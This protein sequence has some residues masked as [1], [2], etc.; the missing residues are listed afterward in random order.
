MRILALSHDLPS[1]YFSDTL[2]VF[3]FLRNLSQVHGHQITLV[4][5]YSERGSKADLQMLAQFCTIGGIFPIK[6]TI[7]MH[8]KTLEFI[9]NTVIHN[10]LTR[11]E[12]GITAADFYFSSSM[13]HRVEDLL[14]EEND[15]V[16]LTWPMGDY[17]RHAS[18]PKVL[19]LFDALD[20]WNAQVSKSHRGVQKYVDLA[21]SLLFE[22]F[23]R[24]I[25]EFNVSLIPT[26]RDKT[27]VGR[28]SPSADIRV[29]PLGVDTESFKPGDFL[30]QRPSLIF[31]SDMSGAP[32]VTNVI[33]FYTKVYPIICRAIP[34][35]RLY[36]VG[37]NPAPE[38]ARLS[39]DPSVVVTGYV[40][41]VKPY[42]ARAHVFVAPMITGTGMKNKV[43][44]A[45]AMGKSIVSTAEGARGLDV[46]P[47]EH[48]LLAD[49]PMAFAQCVIALLKDEG[50]RRFL[51]ANARALVERKYSW[52][53][54]TGLMNMIIEET[55]GNRRTA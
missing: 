35:V 26:Q 8:Q 10:L 54:V 30:D 21:T 2:P 22:K 7:S 50:K 4:T 19:Q 27:L 16:Y 24:G 5:F 53:V 6:R 51:G 55:A 14:Q 38:I 43:L 13:A 15:L 23:E 36:L 41:S 44:E 47:G 37:R 31:V 46:V 9:S 39:L 11:F 20:E 29:V 40:E 33:F 1:P 25:T 3:H 52:E 28:W 42:L 32:T 48:L 34:E 17:V 18:A 12:S 45:M 49:D